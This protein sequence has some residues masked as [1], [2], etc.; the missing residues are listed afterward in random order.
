MS[1]ITAATTEKPSPAGGDAAGPKTPEIKPASVQVDVAGHVSRS[2]IVRAPEGMVADDL[3][4]PK[5]WRLV[6][7]SQAASLLKMDRLLIIAFDESWIVEAL[8]KFV[9]NSE[10]RLLILKVASFAQVGVDGLFSDGTLEVFWDG[11]SYGFRRM[12]DKVPLGRG[13]SSEGLAIDGLRR[14]YPRRVGT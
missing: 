6:Q 9:S 11:G 2:V 8:V 12:T 5:V 3:R 1:K 14:H 10:A 7:G 4:D 13:F